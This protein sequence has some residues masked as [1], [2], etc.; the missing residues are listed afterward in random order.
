MLAVR[1]VGD[2]FQLFHIRIFDTNGIQDDA[3]PPQAQSVRIHIILGLAISDHHGN[4]WDVLPSSAS[5]CLHKVPLKQKV[6][7]LARVGASTQVW[8]RADVLE[9]VAFILVGVE[10]ELGPWC[11]AVLYQADADVVGPNVKTADQCVEEATDLLKILG[12]D[13]PRSVHHEDDVSHG[14]LGAD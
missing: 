11:G 10:S 12:T 6:Q 9:D 7:A 8:Q 1:L 3:L 5:S 14:L 4:L 13:T 2:L